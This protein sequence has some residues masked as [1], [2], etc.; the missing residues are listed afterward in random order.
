MCQPFQFDIVF[1]YEDDFF[2]SFSLSFYLLYN[3][4]DILF[5]RRFSIFFLFSLIFWFQNYVFSVSFQHY[6]LQV[7]LLS[8]YLKSTKSVVCVKLPMIES[9]CSKIEK[10]WI[11]CY[12]DHKLLEINMDLWLKFTRGNFSLPSILRQTGKNSHRRHR[13]V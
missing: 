4:Y 8:L 2:L 12:K 5:P 7:N 6:S 9:C 10:D 1:T 3:Y 11:C 13:N